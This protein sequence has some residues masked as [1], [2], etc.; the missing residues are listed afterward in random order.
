[1]L[2]EADEYDQY[3]LLELT[4]EELAAVDASMLQHFE[5]ESSTSKQSTHQTHTHIHVQYEET[6]FKGAKFFHALYDPPDIY[7]DTPQAVHSEPHVGEPSPYERFRRNKTFSVTDM[8]GPSWYASKSC[9]R[10]LCGTDN[11]VS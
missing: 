6:R 2:D 7:V 4:E 11:S 5:P 8:S 9:I 1:M 3:D 10:S